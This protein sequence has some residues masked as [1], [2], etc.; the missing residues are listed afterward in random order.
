[1][2]RILGT[3]S[4]CGGPVTVPAVW[5]GTIPPTPT[6]GRCGAVAVS[7]HGPRIETERPPK[8]WASSHTKPIE[9]SK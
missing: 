7:G 5:N 4:R 2:D 9:G 6:C 8:Q 1:M 3:C